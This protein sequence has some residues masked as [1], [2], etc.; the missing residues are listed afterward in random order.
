MKTCLFYLVNTVAAH[1][2]DVTM[3]AIASQITNL[4]IVYSTVYSDTGRRKHQN[5]ASLAFVRGIHRE[6][7]NSPYK[8]PVTRKNVSIWWRHH[9]WPGDTKSQG[10]D[11][12]TF[13]DL[14]KIFSRI[15][16]IAGIVLLMRISSWNFVRVPKA[17]TY[18]ISAWNSR[19][20]C[21]FRYCVFSRDY[22]GEFVK[23]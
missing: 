15:L 7:A 1:Y 20:K 8:G 12:L 23:R 9:G 11:S 18:T 14:S 13:R 22:L 10:I 3:S 16:W 2:N 17:Q 6:P 4:A 21:V 19:H 5:S